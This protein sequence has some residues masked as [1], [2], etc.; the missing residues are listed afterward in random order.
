[1]SGKLDMSLMYAMHNALR[2]ELEQ[3]ARITA[4][5]DDDPRRFLTGAVGWD[6][7]KKALHIHHTAEDEALWPV[8]RE[9][10]A[11]RPDDLA[12]LDAMDAEHGA[13]DPLIVTID[14]ALA[15]PEGGPERLAAAVDALATN[16]TGH[17]KHEEDEA[18]P[19]IEATLSLEQWQHYGQVHGA[20]TGP[21]GPVL[22]PWVLDGADEQTITTMLAILPEPVRAAYHN[23]WQ[24]SYA[25]L[26]KWNTKS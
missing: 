16:L 24:P 19:L 9:I 25:A 26:D 1:M 17:L 23:A 12:L 20:K 15:D 8:V 11:G 10:V 2:R 4:R 21:D 7:F 13:I 22:T 18:L 14:A 5:V 6:I 3:M